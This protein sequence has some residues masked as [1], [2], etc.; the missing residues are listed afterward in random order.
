MLSQ[1]LILASQSPRRRELLAAAGFD[2]SIMRPRDDANETPFA[3]ESPQDF[4]QRLAEQKARS[5]AD[6]VESGLILGC[7]TVAVFGEKVLGKP[8]DRA[9]ARSMLGLMRGNEH[10]VYSGVCLLDAEHGGVMVR[11]D[12]TLLKM[13]D[14]SDNRIDTYLE[15]ELWQGKA[16][17]FGFQDGLEW[18]HIVRGS[19]SN[20]VGLPMELLHGMLNAFTRPDGDTC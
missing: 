18:V 17:A 15:T 3:G 16:G 8:R 9:D 5:V 4:V 12:E 13:E 19:A 20:V 10:F 7:D 6:K 1:P 2:F 11:S 14:I